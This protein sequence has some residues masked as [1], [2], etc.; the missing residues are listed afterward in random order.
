M[1]REYQQGNY[2][3]KAKRKMLHCSRTWSQRDKSITER[4]WKTYRRM[5]YG[6]TW[7]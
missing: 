1:W 6:K 4:N 2:R 5:D 3:K 7:G